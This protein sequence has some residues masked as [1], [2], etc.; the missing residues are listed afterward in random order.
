MTALIEAQCHFPTLCDIYCLSVL[1][2]WELAPNCSM[3]PQISD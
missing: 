2:S 3:K 1:Y